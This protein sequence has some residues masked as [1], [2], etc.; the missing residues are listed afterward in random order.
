MR[1]ATVVLILKGNPISEI[2]LGYKK[3]GFGKGK[4]AGF[5]GKIE[6]GEQVSETA[7]RELTE[8]TGVFVPDPETLKFNAILEFCFP[9]KPAWD[10]R[11]FVFFTHHWEGVPVESNEMVPHWFDVKDIPYDQ[12]WDDARY[13]LPKTLSEEQFKA[14]FEFRADNQTVAFVKFSPMD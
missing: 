2:L 6:H 11:V 9:F 1:D 8:E 7:L 14:Y 5:G 13:W 3:I 10:H 4:Y 12:M